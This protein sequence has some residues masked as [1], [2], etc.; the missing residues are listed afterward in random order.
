VAV[1]NQG[2]GTFRHRAPID[3]GQ[4]R[5]RF[6]L[7]SVHCVYLA[8]CKYKTAG[9]VI[10]SRDF[11]HLPVCKLLITSSISF[12]NATAGSFNASP[13]S[14]LLHIY[15]S[16][17]MRPDVQH[18]TG[19]PSRRPGVERSDLVRQRKAGLFQ[20]LRPDCSVGRHLTDAGSCAM[21]NAQLTDGGPP[22]APELSEPTA[23][24]PFGE[25]PVPLFGPQSPY[26]W[27]SLRNTRSAT[28]MNG[29]A[30]ARMTIL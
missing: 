28:R 16:S 15:A 20:K 26:A 29:S 3:P 4:L 9:S 8:N 7:V 21:P 2:T 1:P 12:N 17:S 27:S 14:A 11:G 6:R 5:Q 23:G 25:A 13:K 22:P 24:P 18:E 30:T 10:R 19:V